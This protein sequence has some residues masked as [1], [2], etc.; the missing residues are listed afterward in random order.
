MS[1]LLLDAGNTALKWALVPAAA[2]QWPEYD[3]AADADA[4]NPRCADQTDARQLRGT[5]AI[6]APDLARSLATKLARSAAPTTVVGCAVASE[7]AIATIEAAVRAACGQPVQWLTA[8]ARFDHG[9]ISVRNSYRSPQKLGADRWHALIG[10]HAR[11]PHEAVVVVNAGT[12]TT[13]DGLDA[14]GTFLGGVIVPGIELMR[15]SLAHGTARLPLAAGAYV[16]GPDNTDDAIRTGIVDAQIGAIERRVRRVCEQA[17]GPARVVLSGG[18]ASQLFAL[19]QAQSGFGKMSQ[20]PDLV[21]QGLWCRAR[22]L[23]AALHALADRP[24]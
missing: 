10:A 15:A 21:L 16:D 20:E 1:W 3:C 7:E 14:S 17:G 6:D 4:G 11:F 13:I 8:T 2:D 23:T 22:E 12:A 18:K 19:L 24:S 5:L 9:G